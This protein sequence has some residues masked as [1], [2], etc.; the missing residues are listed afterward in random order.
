M[1]GVEVHLHIEI[2]GGLV[3]YFDEASSEE[4]DVPIIIHR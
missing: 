4:R 1:Y 3:S 2:W